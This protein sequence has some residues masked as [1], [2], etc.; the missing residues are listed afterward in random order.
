MQQAAHCPWQHCTA[1]L[2]TTCSALH[3]LHRD[4]SPLK[5]LDASATLSS[6]R[7]LSCLTPPLYIHVLSNNRGPLF[8]SAALTT[9]SRSPLLFDT[10]LAHNGCPPCLVRQGD[11]SRLPQGPERPRGRACAPHAQHCR[12]SARSAGG[13]RV[14]AGRPYDAWPEPVSIHRVVKALCRG[15]RGSRGACI[16]GN[17]ARRRRRRRAPIDGGPAR[18]SLRTR[19]RRAMAP[20]LRRCRNTT[21]LLTHTRHPPPPPPSSLPNPQK[22]HRVHRRARRR[23]RRDDRR[24]PPGAARRRARQPH[25]A[26]RAARRARRV[27]HQD[28]GAVGP[29]RVR[30]GA[31]LR[32]VSELVTRAEQEERVGRGRGRGRAERSCLL[33]CVRAVRCA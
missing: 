28:D 3:A 25:G 21:L 14:A 2:L 23:R 6:V 22:Q 8:S 26:R 18:P 29:Q 33:C 5:Y 7:V 16:G 17:C 32:R 20:P 24:G 30:R 27:V 10:Q 9:L 13:P 4:R 1:A 31:A 19:A 15:G 12:A 11:R